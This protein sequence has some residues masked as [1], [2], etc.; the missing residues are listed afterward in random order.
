V[1]AVEADEAVAQGDLPLDRGGQQHFAEDRRRLG[2]HRGRMVIE[3]RLPGGQ[4][5]VEAVAQLVGHGEHVAQRPG[6]VEQ[7]ERVRAGPRPVAVRPA[8]LVAAHRGV[9][10]PLLEEPLGQGA[11]LG[12]EAAEGVHD[13][14][15]RPGKGD[16]AD[17]LAHR[18]VQV[19][20]A[21]ARLA[22]DP[23][24]EPV[25]FLDQPVLV[26]DPVHHQPDRRLLHLVGQ[27]GG[28]GAV[29]EPPQLAFDAV[30]ADQAVED[31]GDGLPVAGVLAIVGAHHPRPH[32]R[33][34][35]VKQVARRR[36]RQALPAP[37]QGHRKGHGGGELVVEPD[38]RVLAGDILLAD[39][40]F[41]FLVE[42]V[43]PVA[44]DLPEEVAVGRQLRG[45]GDPVEYALRQRQQ[46][47]AE[48]DHSLVQARRHLVGPD[49]QAAE[50]G[51]GRVR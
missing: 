45:G 28:S 23:R 29:G 46:L 13:Q 5:V 51:V 30:V 42:L 41:L 34:R 4:Q 37:V 36:P 35:V 49:Q 3:I 26:G 2:G 18:G 8:P 15:P 1:A 22:Q 48:E 43:R 14:R 32:R 7:H 20:T 9:D 31:G 6:V 19:G 33:L 50:G 39:E 40:D 21:H 47:Q 44:G 12:V 17:R 11:E 24:L 10:P 27:V 25:V 38:E 16:V